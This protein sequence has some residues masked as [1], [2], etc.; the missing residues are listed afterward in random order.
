MRTT[1]LLFRQ[2]E[3]RFR[4]ERQPR[5]AVTPLTAEQKFYLLLTLILCATACVLTLG[6][7]SLLR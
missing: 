5:Q 2:G 1:E 3:G 7:F 4:V 6:F